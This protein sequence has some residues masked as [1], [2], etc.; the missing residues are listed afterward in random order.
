MITSIFGVQGIVLD[1]MGWVL[2]KR[3][4]LQ[5]IIPSGFSRVSLS[6]MA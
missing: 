1:D 4:C 3:I 5:C 6:D 2:S